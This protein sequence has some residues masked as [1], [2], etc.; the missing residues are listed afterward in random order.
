MQTLKSVEA[1]PY[2]LVLVTPAGRDSFSKKFCLSFQVLSR[3]RRGYDINM[4]QMITGRWM[5]NTLIT[6]ETFHHAGLRVAIH[7]GWRAPA[8]LKAA[9]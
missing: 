8:A 4:D 5:L 3:W 7:F 9:L 1:L 6:I 2:G